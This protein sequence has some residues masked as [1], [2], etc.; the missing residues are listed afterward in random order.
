MSRKSLKSFPSTKENGPSKKVLE[1]YGAPSKGPRNPLQDLCDNIPQPNK[2]SNNIKFRKSTSKV[3]SAKTSEVKTV[4]SKSSSAVETRIKCSLEPQ[5][6]TERQPDDDEIVSNE[7]DVFVEEKHHLNYLSESKDVNHISNDV[8]P[9]PVIRITRPPAEDIQVRKPARKVTLVRKLS[10]R[11]KRCTEEDFYK[12]CL[13]DADYFEENYAYMLE[14]EKYFVFRKDLLSKVFDF[15]YRVTVVNWLISVQQVLRS[16]QPTFFI[17]I[18]MFDCMLLS[19]KISSNLYELV[20]ITCL[21]IANKSFDVHFIQIPKLVSLC[22]GKYSRQQFLSAE[23]QVLKTLKFDT[24][25]GE[26]TSFLFYYLHREKLE[27]NLKVRYSAMFLLEVFTLLLDFS[28]LRP[29]LLACVSLYLVLVKYDLEN[30]SF[31]NYVNGNLIERD[32]F[33]RK[34]NH[35]EHCVKQLLMCKAATEE[36]VKKYSTAG[37]CFAAKNFVQNE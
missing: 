33:L 11:C 6:I 7:D 15:N 10:N 2:A 20:A 29:S 5:I 18:R 21:W 34:S 4:R 23:K 27:N 3:P 14:R 19:T 31:L 32:I 26:P 12:D 24:N 13:Y 22:N 35:L 1:K 16:T 36:V 9:V 28:S 17:A 25:L 8:Q 37:T 30:S